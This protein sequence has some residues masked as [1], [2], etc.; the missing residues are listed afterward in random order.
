MCSNKATTW[1]QRSQVR[2]DEIQALTSALNI[3]KGAVSETT[4]GSTMRLTQQGVSV[5]LAKQFAKDSD[6]MVDLEAET[7]DFEAEKST[8]FLQKRQVTLHT[9]ASKDGRLEIIS[10]LKNKGKQLKSQV[11]V[12]LA[13]QIEAAKEDPFA[14]VKTLIQE[15]IERL[16]QEAANEA[17]QKEWCD[18]AN[19]DAEQ[20][21]DTA[22]EEIR[23]LNSKIATLEARIDGLKQDIAKLT[24]EITD[25]ENKKQEAID[26]RAKE[27]A[28]NQATVD[29]ANAG[30]SAVQQAISLL[31]DFYSSAGA[32]AASFAQKQSPGSD[33]PNAGFDGEYKGKVSE[34]GGVIG[35][36]E[37]IEGDFQR[38]V[39]ET[40]KAESEAEEDHQIFLTETDKVLAEKNEAKTALTTQ[41][42]EA[43][44]ELNTDMGSL[45][46]ETATLQSALQELLE[47]QPAC[48]DTG[49][50]YQDRVDNR[51]QEIAALKQ[52]LCILSAY[53]EYGASFTSDQC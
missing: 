22:A 13:G 23:A 11:L 43:E 33:A 5:A 39:T 7:E 30:L 15:L 37:V 35:M 31:K 29:E 26:M 36:L 24:E 51:A 6:S 2:S 20:K 41:K 9:P 38:T 18:K 40:E 1:D 48:I 52:A 25:L 19:S 47:L 34:A 3:I 12:A 49:M 14:K 46:S 44:E 27:Q 17:T 53:A 50:S 4:S 21:R 42:D 10:L 45:D 28:E 32:P 8:A 16:Q